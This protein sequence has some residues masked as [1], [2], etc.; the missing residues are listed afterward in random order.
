LYDSPV[1]RQEFLVY[2]DLLELQHQP[3]SRRDGENACTKPVVTFWVFRSSVGI[4]FDLQVIESSPMVPGRA[5]FVDML[6]KVRMCLPIMHKDI[7]EAFI[8]F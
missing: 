7:L 4:S 6:M 8:Q 1:H 2:L 5:L 3:V